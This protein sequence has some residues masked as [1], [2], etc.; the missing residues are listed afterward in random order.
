MA[1]S[2][3]LCASPIWKDEIHPPAARKV[4]ELIVAFPRERCARLPSAAEHLVSGVGLLRVGAQGV[5]SDSC[6][7]GSLIGSVP[8]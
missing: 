7:T 1:G 4:I 5:S 6:W 8:V 2:A 3:H